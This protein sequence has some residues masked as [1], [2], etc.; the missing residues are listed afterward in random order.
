MHGVSLLKPIKVLIPKAKAKKGTVS[1][2]DVAL[3]YI[4]KLYRVESN[5]ATK[6]MKSV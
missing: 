2:A 5:I 3:S 6:P 4:R 1:K